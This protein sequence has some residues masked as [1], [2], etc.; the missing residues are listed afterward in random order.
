MATN[1]YSQIESTLEK[2]K[3]TRTESGQKQKDELALQNEELLQ[4]AQKTFD[5][6][7]EKTNEDYE[8]IAKAAALQKELDLRDI[9]EARAN[10][11]L[12]R[13][14]LSSTEQTAAILSAGNKQAKALRQKQEAVDSLKK[15][16]MDYKTELDTKLRQQYLAIDTDIENQ[17]ATERAEL[18]KQA[19]ELTSK[20]YQ[21]EM[22]ARS[23]INTIS[24]D[25]YEK[26][27]NAISAAKTEVDARTLRD[28]MIGA[29][30]S[31]T[32]AFALF[33]E[34]QRNRGNTSSKPPLE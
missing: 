32:T 31:E 22:K 34:W 29:G 28:S 12:S 26:W 21:E 19:N 25:D 27:R 33:A 1:Y 2:N 17:T 4:S 6:N 23:K 30:V 14:G 18:L 16:L 7:V 8:D 10:M 5:E 9:R 11:G 15:S 3:K 13:S 20:E 24:Y